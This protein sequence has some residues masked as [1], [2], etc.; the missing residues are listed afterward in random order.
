[1]FLGQYGWIAVWENKM[2][3]LEWVHVSGIDENSL[4]LIDCR[5]AETHEEWEQRFDLREDWFQTYY[6]SGQAGK[7]LDV[8]EK[9]L[10]E[11]V[12]EF[13]DSDDR[14]WCAQ[15]LNLRLRS[16]EATPIFAALYSG[17]QGNFQYFSAYA[18]AM[19][20][21]GNGRKVVELLC[22]PDR[23]YA[24][25]EKNNAEEIV[26]S[27]LHRLIATTYSQLGKPNDARKNYALS[28]E[29]LQ[30]ALRQQDHVIA[31][32]ALTLSLFGR[33]HRRT[34]KLAD[35]KQCFAE[36]QKLFASLMLTEPGRYVLPNTG[37]MLRLAELAANTGKPQEA[38][39]HF[40]AAIETYRHLPGQLLSHRQQF[41]AVLLTGANFYRNIQQ[42]D[43]AERLLREAMP[44]VELTNVEGN[45]R[46]NQFAKTSNLL[47][48][49]LADQSRLDEAEGFHAEALDV[50]KELAANDPNSR[51]EFAI[52]CKALAN[53]C[54][55]LGK[56]EQART[57]ENTRDLCLT[58]PQSQH[59]QG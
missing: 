36:A 20:A 37:S 1:M 39:Q 34:Q 17:A 55:R 10:S 8:P 40:V 23:V 38:A 27:R 59:R 33:H 56:T 28:I 12:R 47:G 50:Y 26:R 18:C 53:I 42:L 51:L 35:A 49:V 52:T 2:Y 9:L 13:P 7:I 46:K 43:I 45:V 16:T 54:R 44:L 11:N 6:W 14:Y 58:S 24:S 29:Y 19:A 31:E 15:Y 30:S 21:Q 25:I 32:S 4:D 5:A 57:Y 3:K 48:Y 22:D 41:S